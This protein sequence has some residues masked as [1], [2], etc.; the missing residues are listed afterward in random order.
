MRLLLFLACLPLVCA[1]SRAPLSWPTSYAPPA[2]AAGYPTSVAINNVDQLVRALEGSTRV[3]HQL[4]LLGGL[5]PGVGASVAD[6]QALL[7]AKVA[8]PV[9]LL[10]WGRPLQPAQLL[11]RAKLPPQEQFL[12]V[13]IRT[14]GIAAPIDAKLAS[15]LRACGMKADMVAFARR[16]V[17][18]PLGITRRAVK[19]PVRA[20]ATR[21]APVGPAVARGLA[22]LARRQHPR[23]HWDT[24]TRHDMHKPAVTALA[25]LAFMASG[26][27][28]RS[29]AH[30]TTVHNG[31]VSLLRDQQASGELGR[32][33]HSPSIAN[34]PLCTLALAE[35]YALT[36]D[37][38]LLERVERAIEWLLRA[39]KPGVPSGWLWRRASTSRAAWAIEALTT[40]QACGL[41]GKAVDEGLRT[42]L[43]LIV[44][45][46]DPKQGLTAESGEGR[47]YSGNNSMDLFGHHQQS[48][49]FNHGPTAMAIAS[50]ALLDVEAGS[51]SK[52]PFLE[53]AGLPSWRKGP[54]GWTADTH[55]WYQIQRMLLHVGSPDL[56]KTYDDALRKVLLP[57]QIADGPMAGSWPKGEEATSMTGGYPGVTAMAIL[58]LR[59]PHRSA[60]RKDRRHPLTFKKLEAMVAARSLSSKLVNAIL[61]STTEVVLTADQLA[62]LERQGAPGAA[63][64]L[65]RNRKLTVAEVVTLAE[66][67][68]PSPTVRKLVEALGCAPVNR[69][70]ARKLR[71]LALDAKLVQELQDGTH[72]H[73][74]R[75]HARGGAPD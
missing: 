34:H 52:T 45:L 72:D 43:K 14:L 37:S 24:N 25:L 70:R 38:R 61:R 60:P 16:F 17:R 73:D 11:E 42:E 74:P 22:F 8:E 71:R 29:G 13:L 50:M 67:R 46:T 12:Y 66:E 33:S 36:G 41:G 48:M 7:K 40:A 53:P 32:E 21:E 39:R 1:Q 58:A 54:R 44:S 65:L 64:M 10:V 62:L 68:T 20:F 51:R 26:H 5:Q 30:A 4:R 57:R 23:G 3:Q 9:R 47:W 49:A 63:L 55:A 18:R 15:D 35:A 59:A 69:Y 2:R 27:T 56:R 75:P 19:L 31:L 28:H 6:Q